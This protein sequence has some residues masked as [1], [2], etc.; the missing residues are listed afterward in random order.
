MANRGH[1]SSANA[2]WSRF[3]VRA[4]QQA[5]DSWSRVARQAAPQ[6][7]PRPE[8]L[9]TLWSDGLE[10]LWQD[11]GAQLSGTSHEVFGRLVHQ[12]KGFLFLSHELLRAVERLQ[13][14]AQTGADWKRSLRAAIDGVQDELR[15]C[16]G[17]S[18]GTTAL[19]G[20]PVEMWERLSSA[21]ALTPGD[22][23][24]TLN[25]AMGQPVGGEGGSF[26]WLSHWPALG[27][28]REWQSHAQQG[29]Q[30]AERYQEAWRRYAAKLLDVSV[31]ALDY[32]YERLVEAGDTGQ[33]IRQL[34]TVY[35]LWVDAAEQSYAEVVSTPEFAGLQAE[36]INA[37]VALK[38]HLQESLEAAARANSLPTRTEIDSAHR[39]IKALRAELESLRTQLAT[40]T[41]ARGRNG[42]D[43]RE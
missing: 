26:D 39:S 1:D 19:W 38:L 24:Q 18:L 40:A 22:W 23:A 7:Q 35:D 42:K 25:D 34:R 15:R 13:T 3:W 32:F 16:S 21:L 4:Q 12:G 41:P 31:L 36:V 11:R 14:E 17:A 10:R 2:D 37:A 43:P 30:R 9:W 27:V 29:A 20:L 8:D 33:R 28:T 5:W 6:A